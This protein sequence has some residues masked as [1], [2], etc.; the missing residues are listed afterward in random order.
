MSN[1][2]S[3]KKGEKRPNQGKRGPDKMQRD[4]REA[5]LIVAD[6]L[7]GPDRMLAWAQEDPKN[8]QL[9]W[10]SIY[11]KL[12]PKDVKAE[13][14]ATHIIQKMPPEQLT[15]IIEGALVKHG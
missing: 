5:I 14:I 6:K 3:F 15:G 8:E 13:I 10:G 2:G 4:V 9:F 11:P 1:P 7:G 12:L